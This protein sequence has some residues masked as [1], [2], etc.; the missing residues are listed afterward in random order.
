MAIV[1]SYIRFSSRKQMKGDSLRRQSEM[2]QEWIARNQHTAAN[3]TLHDLGVSAF[4]GKNKHKGALKTFLNAISDGTIKPGSILLVENLDRLSRQGVLEAYTLF[5]DILS[6]GVKIV[7]LQ[8]Y[9]QVYSKQSANDL[10]GLMLP[11]IHFYQAHIESKNKSDR[12]KKSWEQKRKLAVDGVRFDKRCPSWIQYDSKKNCFVK[13]DGWKA[14]LFIFKRTVDGVGQGRLLSEL[15]K[16]GFA[17]L[18][19]SGRWNSSFIQKVLNDRSVLGERQPFTFT[20]DGVREPEGDPIP[21]YYPAVV[22][23]SLWY[24]AQAAKAGRAKQKGPNSK[25]INLFTGLVVNA[26][27]RH[28]MHVQSSPPNNKSD[29][30]RRRLVSYGHKSKLPDSCSISVDYFDFERAILECLTEVSPKNVAP[31]VNDTTLIEKEQER[32][33]VVARLNQ[34]SES[35]TDPTTKLLPTIINAVGKLETQKAELSEEIESLKQKRQS[36]PLY[37]TRSILAML[38]KAEGDSKTALRLK[39]RMLIGNLIES[40]WVRPEKYRNKVWS[41]VQI[42]FKDGGFKHVHMAGGGS[43]FGFGKIETLYK[44]R[45]VVENHFP[46]DD[47]MNIF[48]L[49]DEA[50][51]GWSLLTQLRE[52]DNRKLSIPTTISD[53]LEQAADVWLRIAKNRMSPDS[54]RVVPSK[55]H[56]FVEFIGSQSLCKTL[57]KKKWSK[58]TRCL[59]GKIKS[60]ELSVATA[61]VNYSRARELVVWLAEEDKTELWEGINTAPAQ[62][63]P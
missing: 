52:Q 33:G 42:H 55:I 38:D 37:E 8:P 47:L 5:I 50:S 60:G 51:I 11:L 7:V 63:F 36:N 56:R 6:A 9:E 58:W 27:D 44:N 30:R 62:I 48:D 49:R 57:D 4:R 18:G 59:K 35:L 53:R 41:I 19:I 45:T 29:G 43:S 21:D 10:V 12:L 32:D 15:Q 46:A 13:K 24:Q 22:D 1:Y 26:N 14:I 23:E 20:E 34:L 3:L 61:R 54:Y 17:P 16:K 25:F 28:K 39:L 31:K 2:G 40:I